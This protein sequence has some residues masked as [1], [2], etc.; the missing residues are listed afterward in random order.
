[1]I[2]TLVFFGSASE[3]YSIQPDYLSTIKYLD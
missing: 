3:L 1:L 2:G